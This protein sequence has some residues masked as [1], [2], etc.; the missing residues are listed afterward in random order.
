MD[1]DHKEGLRAFEKRSG[2]D[3][4][5]VYALI[6][7]LLSNAG[8]TIWWASSVESRILNHERRHISIDAYIKEDIHQSHN[9]NVAIAKLQTEFIFLREGVVEIKQ[10]IRQQNEKRDGSR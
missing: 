8:S 6:A 7:G 5:I 2:L 1:L 10:L 4:K 9:L 3:R